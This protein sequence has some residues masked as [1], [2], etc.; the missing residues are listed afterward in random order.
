MAVVIVISAPSTHAVTACTRGTPVGSDSSAA[1]RNRLDWMHSHS[2]GYD[3][4]L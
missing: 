2:A 4:C 1:V 3:P